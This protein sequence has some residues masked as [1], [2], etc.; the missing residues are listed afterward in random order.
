MAS[1]IPNLV[2]K[3]EKGEPSKTGKE[4]RRPALTNIS[5]VLPVDKQPVNRPVTRAYAKLLADAQA[6]AAVPAGTKET[7]W[8]SEYMGFQKGINPRMREIL[9]D[10]IIDMHEY[11]QLRP[12]TLYLSIYIVDRYLS[13][14]LKPIRRIEIQLIGLCSILLASKYEEIWHPRVSD[15]INGCRNAYT[16]RDALDMEKRIINKLG[17]YL[18]IPTPYMFLVRFI[19]TSNDD[20]ELENMI[21][22]FAELALMNYSLI[23]YV[24]SFLAA[25]CVYAA[26]GTLSK[27][28]IWNRQLAYYTG[29]SEPQIWQ[30]ARILLISHLDAS[31]GK[32]SAVYKKYSEKKLGKVALR[33]PVSI[34]ECLSSKPDFSNPPSTSS[35]GF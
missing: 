17:W 6:A 21:Y 15:L 20:T 9:M 32:Y 11:F 27:T 1:K 7:Y 29:Y 16:L 2:S 10:W 22:F 12:E 19:K 34:A 18:T 14:E 13:L 31:E 4:V 25:C 26:R 23:R 35:A 3:K 5:N 33:R 8:P 30:C 24:P 28:P